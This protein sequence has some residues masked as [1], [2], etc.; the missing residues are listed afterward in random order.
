MLER[1]RAIVSCASRDARS[2]A[3]SAAG[4]SRM[5]F[6]AAILLHVNKE[7]QTAGFNRIFGN[8]GRGQNV[9]KPQTPFD[10]EHHAERY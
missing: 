1:K 3:T 4:R 10:G 5:R 6:A 7:R 9:E 8:F 2:N